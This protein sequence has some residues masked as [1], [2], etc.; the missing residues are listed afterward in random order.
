MSASILDLARRR[1]VLL[2]G[3]LGT[4]L[5]RRGLP[6]GVP[7]EL[8]N[9]ERPDVVRSV[10]R[11]Y[12]AAGSDAVSTSS[13]GGSPL[14]LGAYGLGERCAELN[15]AAAANAL[16]V[17]PEGKFVAGS[18]G[19]TGRFLEPQGDLTISGLETAFAEQARGLAEGGV[20]FFILETQYDLREALS[21][22]RAARAAAPGRPVLVTMTFNATPRGYFTM[23]GDS[24]ARAFEELEK[25]GADAVGANCQLDSAQ[26]AGLAKVMA[27]LTSLPLVVQANSGQP[28]VDPDGRVTF[29]QTADDYLRH[30]PDILAAGVRFLGGCCGT[31]PETIRKM[32][33][34][35]GR[36][37]TA[38][39]QKP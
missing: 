35:L 14:K 36:S 5:M 1:V 22:L 32:A 18:M 39:G 2:D 3:A 15:R 16:A 29:G 37:A 34:L 17:R 12:Y 19:P 8:W 28:S 23:M 4:E 9:V 10:H 30:I 21:A 20:D 13:F 38:A 7:P 11:E 25:A 26:M 31:T 6:Q 27:G 24:V 33:E